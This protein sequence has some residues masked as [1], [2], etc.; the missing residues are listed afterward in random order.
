MKEVESFEIAKEYLG[1]T[2]EAEIDRPLGSLHPKHG[3]LYESNYGFVP[4]TK[5]PDG[6]ELDA[7]YL[8]TDKPV[9][10][11]Q[12]VCIA[13]IHRTNDNDDKLVI[14]PEGQDL[15]DEE[16]EKAVHFQEQFFKHEIVRKV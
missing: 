10:K 11:A 8:G 3:F 12:G 15:S 1:K 2:V 5:A 6:E 16:I 13:V 7:Y 9:E 14:V 4:G